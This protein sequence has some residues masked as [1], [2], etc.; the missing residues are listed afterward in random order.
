MNY[1]RIYISDFNVNFQQEHQWL[2]AHVKRQ[3]HITIT[4][5]A[6][7]QI[8]KNPSLVCHQLHYIRVLKMMQFL[9][10]TRRPKSPTIWMNLIR[11][12]P[13]RA[14]HFETILNEVIKKLNDAMN[15][16]KITSP[17]EEI[18]IETCIYAKPRKP[19]SRIPRRVSVCDRWLARLFLDWFK[20][21][22]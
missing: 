21:S 5:L 18:T 20:R 11:S 19:N 9:V 1:S 3:P 13:S 6:L 7:N 22:L 8:D 12:Y 15:R 10:Q 2:A 14:Y 16:V 17:W 4:A